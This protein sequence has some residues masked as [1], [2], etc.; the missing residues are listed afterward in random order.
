M[1]ILN[2]LGDRVSDGAEWVG[3]RV[4]DGVHWVGDTARE[5]GGHVVDAGAH[6]VDAAGNVLKAEGNILKAGGNTILAGGYWLTGDDAEARRRLGDA[7]GNLRDA[8]GNAVRAGGDVVGGLAEIGKAAATPFA[9]VGE[10]IWEGLGWLGEAIDGMFTKIGNFLGGLLKKLFDW[11]APWFEK[12]MNLMKLWWEKIKKKAEELYRGFRAPE[13]LT[14]LAR[15]WDSTICTHL[16]GLHN[17]I[18]SQRLRADE[19]WNSAAGSAY[20]STLPGQQAAV[21][22]LHGLS[23]NTAQQL[24]DAAVAIKAL[25]GEAGSAVGQ[26]A[27]E[28]KN[29]AG[30]E[31]GA[32]RVIGILGNVLSMIFDISGRM[33]DF[34]TKMSGIQDNLAQSVAK[35]GAFPGGNWPK[36][37]LA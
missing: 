9:R 12:I 11:L 14:E 18:S 10:A 27:G 32:S 6:F 15:R 25:Y 31:S 37:V 24:R 26:G 2:W 3:D 19:G 33:Q 1:S 17:G 35:S 16:S 21:K 34:S 23:T 8:A 13:H 4:A 29:T 22:A 30:N 36:A 20:K 5:M 28:I 7:G